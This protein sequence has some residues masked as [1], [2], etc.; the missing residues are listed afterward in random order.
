MASV[1]EHHSFRSVFNCF[2]EFKVITGAVFAAYAVAFNVRFVHN[3]KTELVTKFIEKLCVG[4]M[5]CADCIYVGTL[6]QMKVLIISFG[7]HVPAV[8][9]VKIVAVNALDDNSFAVHI[10]HVAL[11]F[12]LSETD[13]D[14]L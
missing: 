13:A 3:V 9:G 12:H 2:T 14:A 1:T 11:D 10:E 7:G 5:A 6:H 4:I 8:V